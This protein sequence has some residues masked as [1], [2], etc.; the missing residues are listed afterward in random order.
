[1]RGFRET[2]EVWSTQVVGMGVR[3]GSEWWNEQIRDAG[4]PLSSL[5]LI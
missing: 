1:M 5:S 4:Q 2:S 3:K